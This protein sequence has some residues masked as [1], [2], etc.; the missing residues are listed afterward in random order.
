MGK[1][2]ESD[3]EDEVNEEGEGSLSDALKTV[4]DKPNETV[5]VLQPF[6]HHFQTQKTKAYWFEMGKFFLIMIFS[7]GVIALTWDLAR[8]DVIGGE[9]FTLL[10]G[11]IVGSLL[12]FMGKLHFVKG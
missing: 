12:T 3:D 9:S 11:T 2:G 5:N 8:N 1:K 7:G 6:F 4:L 10:L